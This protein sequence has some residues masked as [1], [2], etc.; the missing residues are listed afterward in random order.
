MFVRAGER[1]LIVT[2]FGVAIVER[3]TIVAEYF[4]DRTTDDRVRIA[5]VSR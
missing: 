5:A 3:N 4:L 2:E 1:L